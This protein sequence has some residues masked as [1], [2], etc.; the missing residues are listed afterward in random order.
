MG[1]APVVGSSTLVSYGG[2]GM[3]LMALWVDPR[4]PQTEG[5]DFKRLILRATER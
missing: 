3:P 4:H 1:M 5:D 2:H